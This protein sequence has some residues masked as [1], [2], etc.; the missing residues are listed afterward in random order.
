MMYINC[1][2]SLTLSLHDF[3]FHIYWSSNIIIL[4]VLHYTTSN[5]VIKNKTTDYSSGLPVDVFHG[6]RITKCLN[7][8]NQ[9]SR[10]KFDCCVDHSARARIIMRKSDVGTPTLE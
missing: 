2:E 3:E 1:Y 9:L 5:L 10:A 7:V 8:G 4:T 6:L